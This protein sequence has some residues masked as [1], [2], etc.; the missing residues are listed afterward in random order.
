MFKIQFF[1]ASGGVT[2]SSYLLTGTNGDTVLVDLGMFQGIDNNNNENLQA[3]QFDVNSLNA[4]FITHA[5]LDHCGRL[6]FLIKQ[7][8]TG[9]IFATKPTK[10]IVKISL[11]DAAAISEEKEGEQIY[12][13]EEVESV[14][15]IIESIEYDKQITVGE[16]NI[17]FR[18]AGHILGS[19]SIEI[20]DSN[21]QKIVFSGDLGNTPEDL[22]E[23]TELI[24]QADFVVMESTYGDCVHPVEDVENILKSEINQVEKS[25]GTLLI[26]A[27]SIERSQEIIHII[28]QLKQSGAIRSA[29]PVYCDS[30]M[31][32]EVTEIFKQFP[33]LYNKDLSNEPDPFNFENLIFTKDVEAS[34]LIADKK[35]A[36]VIIAGSGMLSG[37]RILHHLNNY[38]SIPTTRILFVGYQAYGTL[39]RII[40]EG[41]KQIRL[42]N[43]EINV[44]AVIT[45]IQSLSS[46][47]DQPKL[48]N[49]LQHI[50]NVKKVFIVHG[51]DGQ[52]S[53]LM[54]KIKSELG[55]AD[56]VLPLKNEIHEMI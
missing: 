9:K 30:P 46:H 11:L 47:A 2:G 4:V 23:P 43:K 50:Q 29:T 7:D 1:G 53:A 45:S 21:L 16:F 52:R 19:A 26:P 38:I 14:C 15:G 44:R 28:K 5:H 10:E 17:T 51:E 25:N 33:K 34:K 31:A 13:K 3:L 39:G 55:L 37:G 42:Y 6:P 36:K 20:Q 35:G 18:D 56:I 40:L 48:I 24:N 54:Q 49:W 12:S 22:I 41:A 8:F 27:F 32:I